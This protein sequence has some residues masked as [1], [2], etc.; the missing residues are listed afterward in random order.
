MRGPLST[1]QC[2]KV[3]QAVA[4][5]FEECEI[6]TWPI[7]CFEIARILNY[8]LRPYSSLSPEGMIEAYAKD[9]DG[10]SQVEENP[11]TGLYQYVIYYDDLSG[12]EGRIRWTIFHEIGHIYLGHHDNPDDSNM[13]IEEAEAE[14]FAKN[15]IAPLPIIRYLKIEHAEEIQDTFVTSYEASFNIME[16]YWKRV[17]FGP[18]NMESFEIQVMKMFCVA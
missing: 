6:H 2:N 15:A 9:P 12:N 7:D 18:R 17:Q 8:V 13:I 5:M 10:F 11:E 1:D 3:K 14:L 4:D 16:Y